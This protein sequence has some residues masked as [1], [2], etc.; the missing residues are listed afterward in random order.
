ME[1]MKQQ[2]QDLVRKGKTKKALQELLNY[3]NANDQ[4]SLAQE[5]MAM[6]NKFKS[7]QRDY[8]MGVLSSQEWATVQAQAANGLLQLL[9]DLEEPGTL[10][11]AG[12]TAGKKVF[13]SYNH[14]DS[15]AAQRIKEALEAE[16]HQ[17]TID[18]ESMPTGMDIKEFIDDS[19][20]K[21]DVTLSLVSKNSLLS[22]WVAM[23]TINTLNLAKFNKDKKFIACYLDEEFFKPD[24]RLQVTEI[25]DKK[26]GEL[27]ELMD[28]Y[29]EKKI[30]PTE[31]YSERERLSEL[32]HNLGK[33][34][35]R[36]RNSKSLDM[37]EKQFQQNLPELVKAINS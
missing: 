23:E 18:V 8:R 26:L 36:L 12:Q 5:L 32:R 30:E 28:K 15:N 22:G 9:E 21:T 31:L 2:I 35:E 1:E 19:V 29:R 16:G 11:P 24:F 33:I 10:A 4:K 6:Q 14:K 37:T 20:E 34:L 25:I 13:I 27:D 17:V 3:A 7:G